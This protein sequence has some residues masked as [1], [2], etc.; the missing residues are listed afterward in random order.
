MLRTENW[1]LC[2]LK[3]SLY[4]CVFWCIFFTAVAVDQPV[5][6]LQNESISQGDSISGAHGSGDT[7]PSF[8]KSPVALPERDAAREG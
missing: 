4:V 7:T 1:S 5:C 2:Q 3:V 6:S 8:S